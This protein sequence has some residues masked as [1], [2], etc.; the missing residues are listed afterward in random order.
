[1]QIRFSILFSFLRALYD[2][3]QSTHSFLRSQS[4]RLAQLTYWTRKIYQRTLEIEMQEPLGL[5]NKFTPV[6][7]KNS[8]SLVS[9]NPLAI[10][11]SF[12]FSVTLHCSQ[13][14]HGA[15]AEIIENIGGSYSDTGHRDKEKKRSNKYIFALQNLTSWF[16]DL[17]VLNIMNII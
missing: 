5:L 7:S 8:A 1:M 2:H 15:P 10:L 14:K 12:A 16:L 9:N 11:L 6:G 17:T 4:I 13:T 3:S